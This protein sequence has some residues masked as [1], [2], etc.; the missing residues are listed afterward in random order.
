MRNFLSDVSM[1]LAALIK[2]D[3]TNISPFYVFVFL[4]MSTRTEVSGQ[5]EG[6][7][8]L[9]FYHMGSRCQTQVVTPGWYQA[10]LPTKP[11]CQPSITIL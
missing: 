11:S 1:I 4:H 5:L 9:S 8:P 2:Y 7:S 3:T 6:V 10:P